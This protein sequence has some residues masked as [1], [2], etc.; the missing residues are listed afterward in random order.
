MTTLQIDDMHCEGCVARI[1]K[2]L[3]AVP[4]V[5]NVAVTLAT[6]TAQIRGNPDPATLMQAVEK[7][8]YH[9]RLLENKVS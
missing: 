7:S 2:T 4:G 8:G 9:P 6:H 1:D 3:R 5:T